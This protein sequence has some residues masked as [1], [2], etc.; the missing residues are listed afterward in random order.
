MNEI[1]PEEGKMSYHILYVTLRTFRKKGKT[2]LWRIDRTKKK[3]KTE[4]PQ[5]H[6]H[7]IIRQTRKFK[8]VEDG[9]GGG[10]R[11]CSEKSTRLYK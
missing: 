10:G 11:G 1:M 8:N 7:T 2:F 9:E 6:M 5:P 4:P 3:K